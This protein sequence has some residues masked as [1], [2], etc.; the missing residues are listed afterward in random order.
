LGVRTPSE[1]GGC[2]QSKKAIELYELLQ[3]R[4]DLKQMLIAEKNRLQAPRANLIKE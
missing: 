3:R 1:T 2:R 4:N